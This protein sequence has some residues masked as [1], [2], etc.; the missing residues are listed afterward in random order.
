MWMVDSE[1]TGD[2]TGDQAGPLSLVEECRGSALI[3]RD[4]HSDATPA[5]LCHKEPA[6]ASKDQTGLCLLLAGSFWHNEEEQ[7][8]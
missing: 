7:S 2:W 3:G 6:R 5:L 1:V 4:L 8:H